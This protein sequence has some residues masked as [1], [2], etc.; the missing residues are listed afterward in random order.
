M[1]FASAL[2]LGFGTAQFYVF[3]AVPAPAQTSSAIFFDFSTHACFQ[4][5]IGLLRNDYLK[6]MH[7]LCGINLVKSK[8][9]YVRRGGGDVCVVTEVRKATA[10]EQLLDLFR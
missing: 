7:L 5:D 4:Y 10:A 1:G 9:D 8:N 3:P 2:L 6:K